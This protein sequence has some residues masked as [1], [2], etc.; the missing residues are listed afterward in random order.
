MKRNIIRRYL[1][2]VNNSIDKYKEVYGGNKN[3]F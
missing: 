3:V 1:I 2:D